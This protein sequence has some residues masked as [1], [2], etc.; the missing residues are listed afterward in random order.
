M[1][2]VF[3]GKRTSCSNKRFFLSRVAAATVG[4]SRV[5]QP[6]APSKRMNPRRLTSPVAKE[7]FGSI[8]RNQGYRP[9]EAISM[10]PGSLVMTG[11]AS[12]TPRR[13]EFPREG[14]KENQLKF[15]RDQNLNKQPWTKLSVHLHN[16]TQS[17][18]QSDSGSSWRLSVHLTLSAQ[19]HALRGQHEPTGG[20]RQSGIPFQNPGSRWLPIRQ[21]AGT[22]ADK[23]AVGCLHQIRPGH[24]L[25]WFPAGLEDQPGRSIGLD[26]YWNAHQPVKVRP[27]S[28][29]VSSGR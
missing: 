28:H 8:G 18:S 21:Q 14:A 12:L 22:P 9:G 29:L 6:A 7:T 1:S 3:S 13:Q 27:R 10:H 16:S 26:Q 24:V 4:A 20:L 19:R 23:V 5:P 25:G 2:S 15:S 11:H 17:H